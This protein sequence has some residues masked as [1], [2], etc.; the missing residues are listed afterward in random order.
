MRKILL[1]SSVVSLLLVILSYSYLQYRWKHLWALEIE[2]PPYTLT[3]N[4]DDTLRVVMIGDSWAEIHSALGM[5]SVFQSMLIKRLKVPVKIVSKGKGG[6]KS[7]GIYKLIFD[8]NTEYG[9]ESLITS[10]PDYC[11]I[12]AGINDAAANLGTKQYC[13]HMLLIIKFMLSE[14]IRPILLEIPDVNIWRV[15]GGKPK[16]DLFSDYLRTFMTN[17]KMYNYAEYR[18]ALKSLIVQ[19]GLS[20]SVVY[21]PLGNWNGN[22]TQIEKSLFRDDQIHLNQRGYESLDSAI[23][24]AITDDLRKSGKNIF[25]E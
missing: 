20:D 3:A 6:E 4:D 12:S 23:S 7:K 16:K 18:E 24:V 10:G 11:V 13:H 1:F 2:R 9:T 5:D 22:K 19:E 14:H 17:C 8:D 21:V 25:V 15:Y